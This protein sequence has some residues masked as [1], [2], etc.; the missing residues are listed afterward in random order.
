MSFY[1]HANGA[2]NYANLSMSSM[3]LMGMYI[4]A[5][6]RGISQVKEPGMYPTFRSFDDVYSEN[7]EKT[8][9]ERV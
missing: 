2:V 7:R 8:M 9:V 3:T 4:F 1:F 5:F 6:H